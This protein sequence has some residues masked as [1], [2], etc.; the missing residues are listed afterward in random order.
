MEPEPPALGA[1]SLSHWPTR[2]SQEIFKVER[3][4]SKKL[5]RFLVW[6]FAFAFAPGLEVF[7]HVCMCV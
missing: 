2:K 6:G 5:Y 3:I 7:V 4:L 1:Q